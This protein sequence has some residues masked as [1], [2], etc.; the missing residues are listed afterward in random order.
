MKV[1]NLLHQPLELDFGK[2][3]AVVRFNARETKEI[4]DKYAEH[5]TFKRNEND[6][7][8]IVKPKAVKETATKDVQ[9]DK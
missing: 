9:A 5:K 8:I 3:E 4:P 6:L 2:G 7:Q 1:K